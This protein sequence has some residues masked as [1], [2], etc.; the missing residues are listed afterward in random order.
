M[1]HDELLMMDLVG[2]GDTGGNQQSSSG[3]D[4]MDF[5]KTSPEDLLVRVLEQTLKAYSVD[6]KLASVEVL[7]MID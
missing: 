3:F 2:M 1:Q 7:N 6:E 5:T 4:E